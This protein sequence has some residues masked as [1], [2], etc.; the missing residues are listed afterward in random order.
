RK[1]IAGVETVRHGRRAVP[2]DRRDDQA[3]PTSA[4]AAARFPG[5]RAGAAV[6][7][8]VKATTK[9]FVN[10]GAPPPRTPAALQPLPSPPATGTRDRRRRA[11]A[12]R[13]GGRDRDPAAGDRARRRT[14][15]RSGNTD[16]RQRAALDP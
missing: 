16:R 3:G 8:S 5:P 7:L 2:R 15:S 13:G 14:P 11:P 4:Q 6:T 9:A 10:D 12:R 1:R